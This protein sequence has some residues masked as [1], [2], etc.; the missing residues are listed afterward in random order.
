MEVLHIVRNSTN[1]EIWSPVVYSKVKSQFLIFFLFLLKPWVLDQLNNQKTISAG[2]KALAY[3]WPGHVFHGLWLHLAGIYKV[4]S[5][6]LEGNDR[7]SVA[8]ENLLCECMP[9]SYAGPLYTWRWELLPLTSL[10]TS[11]LYLTAGFP[12]LTEGKEILYLDT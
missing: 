1:G 10:A 7:K 2:F 5:Q 6:T 9:N 3:H 12:T 4:H 8:G 11:W